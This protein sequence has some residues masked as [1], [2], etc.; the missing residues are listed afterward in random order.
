MTSNAPRLP[1]LYTVK[2]TANYLGVSAKTVRRFIDRGQLPCQR[3]GHQIRI[4]DTDIRVLLT[5]PKQSPMLGNPVQY[6]PS[7]RRR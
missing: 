1:R 5:T 3:A 2:E 6:C 7:E 4:S